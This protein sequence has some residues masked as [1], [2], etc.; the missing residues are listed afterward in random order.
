MAENSTNSAP[1]S[2]GQPP[3][4]ISIRFRSLDGQNHSLSSNLSLA[5]ALQMATGGGTAREAIDAV[6][7]DLVNQNA[8][9]ASDDVFHFSLA[10]LRAVATTAHPADQRAL[11][12]E[13][14]SEF[15][16]RQRMQPPDTLG[17]DPAEKP[18]EEREKVERGRQATD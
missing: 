6:G 15:E 1:S 14:K 9:D 12:A 17:A 7:Q 11:I 5:S 2:A 16:R 3:V 18:Q 10:E 4:E 13:R 8:V